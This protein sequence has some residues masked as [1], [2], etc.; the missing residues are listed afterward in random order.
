MSVEVKYY[1][2][3]LGVKNS[4]DAINEIIRLKEIDRIVR[5]AMR[6]SGSPLKKPSRPYEKKETKVLAE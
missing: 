6:D 4:T 3:L 2:D 5:T 1:Y